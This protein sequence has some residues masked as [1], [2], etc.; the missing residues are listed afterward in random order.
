MLVHWPVLVLSLEQMYIC[1]SGT[2]S[3]RVYHDIVMGK[4]TGSVTSSNVVWSSV[5]FFFFVFLFWWW[6]WWWYTVYLSWMVCVFAA[7]SMCWFV[8]NFGE[9]F[10]SIVLFYKCCLRC[11]WSLHVMAAKCWHL[12]H[13]HLF[14][15]L[16]IGGVLAC[17]RHL[18]SHYWSLC[19]CFYANYSCSANLLP[20]LCVTAAF[21]II[22]VI[23]VLRGEH[24]TRK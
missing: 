3:V 24:S 23:W 15:S 2:H 5:L 21:F 17:L 16:S 18:S 6:F 10:Y 14:A 4:Y 7:V 11:H 19:M 12:V 13:L 9:C 20:Y 1:V 22:K 8:Y